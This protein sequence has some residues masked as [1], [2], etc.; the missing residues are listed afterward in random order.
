M[1]EKEEEDVFTGVTHS[2]FMTIIDNIV[3]GIES[4]D[5][6]SNPLAPPKVPVEGEEVEVEE[7]PVTTP[8]KKTV[9]KVKVESDNNKDPLVFDSEADAAKHFGIMKLTVKTYCNGNVTDE[10]GNKWSYDNIC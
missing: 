10:Q 4:G 6:T 5:I 2:E 8:K 7:A 9:K 3:D 1:S